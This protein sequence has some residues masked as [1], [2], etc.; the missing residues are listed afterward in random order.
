MNPLLKNVIAVQGLDKAMKVAQ[1]LIEADYQV[2]IQLEDCNV[3]IVS[4]N[5]ND[6]DL[7]DEIFV[8]LP[9]E[10]VEKILDE[11]EEVECCQY[12]K[13]E[14][15]WERTSD[16]N[17][18]ESEDKWVEEPESY[19]AAARASLAAELKEALKK[20]SPDDIKLNCKGEFTINYDDIPEVEK[21][22]FSDIER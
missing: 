17:E 13:E 3:Y 22:P 9:Q 12:P 1:A 4:Y 7:G 5:P 20:S 8:S 11:E 6:L 21:I 19:S 18:E 16:D 15:E 14:C 10:K 2:M